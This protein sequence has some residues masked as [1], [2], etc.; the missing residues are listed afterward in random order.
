MR[1][2]LGKQKKLVLGNLKAKRDWG[3]S[4][5]YMKA[6]IKI[7]EHDVPDDFVVATGEH[8]SIEDFVIKIFDKLGMDWQDYVEYDARYTRPK[9]VPALLGNPEKIKRVLNWEPE[10]GIDQLIDGMIENDLEEEQ[11]ML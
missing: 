2:K 1:I 5:D 10:I 9:E 6:I 3:H 4:K 11:G 7:L 8:H